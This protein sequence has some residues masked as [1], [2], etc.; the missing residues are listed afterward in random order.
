MW[1]TIES[2]VLRS[3]NRM[4]FPMKPLAALRSL[5]CLV[6]ATRCLVAG[7]SAYEAFASPVRVAARVRGGAEV[8]L[9]ADARRGIGAS[10]DVLSMG[11][12]LKVSRIHAGRVPAEVVEVHPDRNRPDHELIGRSVSGDLTAVDGDAPVTER[13]ARA[14]EHPART[15]TRGQRVGARHW[16]VLVDLG[17]EPLLWRL[18][19]RKAERVAGLSPA[20]PVHGAESVAIR[21]AITARNGTGPLRS[22]ITRYLVERLP[23]ATQLVEVN[24]AEPFSVGEALAF[25]DRAGRPTADTLGHV[26]PPIQVRPCRGLLQQR[27]G[28]F[29][30][31]YPAG[32][33]TDV[34]T[35][36]WFSRQSSS[37]ANRWAMR[38]AAPMYPDE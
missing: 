14:G 27:P 24:R 35:K 15:E 2:G 34:R 36:A 22:P 7:E 11:D 33:T 30:Q 23:V 5:S 37:C 3:A 26:G 9:A 38:I 17:P 8:A 21:R 31:C 18:A 1:F 13:I 28:L 19:W 32:A 10:L 4:A 16:A 20:L 29:S 25:S 6:G 12:R